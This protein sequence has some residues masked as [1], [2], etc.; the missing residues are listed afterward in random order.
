[1]DKEWIVKEY[2]RCADDTVIIEGNRL[3]LDDFKKLKALMSYVNHW[4]GIAEL[5]P[6]HILN[7][8]FDQEKYYRKCAK[9]QANLLAGSMFEDVEE[10]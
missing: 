4:A 9:H 2:Y 8:R 5:K 7:E 3:S 1:M 6:E 10:S